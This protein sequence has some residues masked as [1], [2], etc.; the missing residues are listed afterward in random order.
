MND[1]KVSV[2]MHFRIGQVL[3]QSEFNAICKLL[4]CRPDQQENYSITRG[5]N[6]LAI[7]TRT[8]RVFDNDD[9]LK[10]E[11]LVFWKSDPN[12]LILP[13]FNSKLVSVHDGKSREFKNLNRNKRFSLIGVNVIRTLST[14][15]L[16]YLKH[17]LDNYIEKKKS[18][19]ENEILCSNS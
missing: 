9:D 2:V 12:I 14:P 3:T 8:K 13:L 18:L 7:G 6:T 11:L 19:G 17:Q 15:E 10:L 1:Q 16:F 4:F 5:I